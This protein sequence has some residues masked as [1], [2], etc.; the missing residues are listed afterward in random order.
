M[1]RLYPRNPYGV[2]NRMDGPCKPVESMKTGIIRTYN[3]R[4]SFGFIEPD[5]DREPLVHFHADVLKASGIKKPEEGD[6]VRYQLG[7]DPEQPHRITAVCIE[8]VNEYA[9]DF[10]DLPF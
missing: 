6:K 3:F 4:K 5:N 2:A 8:P 10:T 7:Q 9:I 1:T